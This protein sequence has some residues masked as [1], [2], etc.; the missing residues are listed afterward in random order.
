MVFGKDMIRGMVWNGKIPSRAG[1]RI[2]R[3][4]RRRKDAMKYEVTTDT[5]NAS[6]HTDLWEPQ[7]GLHLWDWW[8]SDD[9]PF[10]SFFLQLVTNKSKTD[11]EVCFLSPHSDALVGYLIS[12][13]L[14]YNDSK[15]K[16]RRLPIIAH[17]HMSPSSAPHRV[18]RCGDDDSACP[19]HRCRASDECQRPSHRL[20]AQT[21]RGQ[22]LRN[23]MKKK[24]HGPSGLG[25]Q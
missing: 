3:H 4:A 8:L 16:Q 5:I 25:A 19:V 11:L 10:T 12:R 6:Y 20:L 2:Y 24:K 1:R 18:L 9:Y 21:A 15:G 23:K 17:P 22:W 7:E 13:V 14:L